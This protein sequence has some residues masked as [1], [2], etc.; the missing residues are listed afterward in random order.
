M[1]G[2]KEDLKSV[3]VTGGGHLE[4]VL[5]HTVYGEGTLDRHGFAVAIVRPYGDGH[6][7]RVAMRWCEQPNRKLG[8][9]QSSARSAWFEVP[10]WM[11]SAILSAAARQNS[12]EIE[13]EVL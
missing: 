9:P 12:R 6:R 5:Y 13:E 2:H 7:R 11:E 1:A 4:E 10:E 8:F 3:F